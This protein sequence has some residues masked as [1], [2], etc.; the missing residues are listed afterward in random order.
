MRHVRN[1]AGVDETSGEWAMRWKEKQ[2]LG[3]CWVSWVTKLNSAEV[4]ILRTEHAPFLL[5]A[6]TANAYFALQRRWRQVTK[7]TPFGLMIFLSLLSAISLCLAVSIYTNIQNNNTH[8]YEI[9][10]NREYGN[11][12]AEYIYRQDKSPPILKQVDWIKYWCNGKFH[13]NL[14]CVM[15]TVRITDRIIEQ[16]R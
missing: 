1:P 16:N 14:M 7:I 9:L 6:Q 15:A 13:V 4:A 3:D 2:E 5:I 12:F 10:L 8:G 11:Y